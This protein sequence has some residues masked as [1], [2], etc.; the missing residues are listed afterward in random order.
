M[1]NQ[2]VSQVNRF[3]QKNFNE[4]VFTIAQNGAKFDSEG[5]KE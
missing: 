5:Q 2:N 3:L 1:R 4:P